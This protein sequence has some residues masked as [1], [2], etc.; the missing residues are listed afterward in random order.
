MPNLMKPSLAKIHVL[1]IIKQPKSKV[2]FR[3]FF[4]G[5]GVIIKW[6][7]FRVH[8]AGQKRMA[9]L[10]DLYL[11]RGAV[12]ML[13]FVSQKESC[14]LYI[15]ITYHE[16]QPSLGKYTYIMSYLGLPMG[17]LGGSSHLVSG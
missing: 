14:T 8:P 4:L 17:V 5:Q 13:V 2:S 3:R 11:K 16:N 7:Q 6:L 15:P 1:L 10:S 12:C 9:I